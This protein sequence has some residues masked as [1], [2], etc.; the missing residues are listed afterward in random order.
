MV[1]ILNGTIHFSCNSLV[2]S[3]MNE[4]MTD[5]HPE[6]SYYYYFLIMREM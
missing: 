6:V 1:Y 3:S 2:N 4:Q 5:T